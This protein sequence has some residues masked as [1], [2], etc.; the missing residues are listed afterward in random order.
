MPQQLPVLVPAHDLGVG[1]Y[2]MW[3]WLLVCVIF[4][5]GRSR[6]F[7]LQVRVQSERLQWGTDSA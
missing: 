7:S 5:S 3:F 1:F 2:R 4:A 6:G